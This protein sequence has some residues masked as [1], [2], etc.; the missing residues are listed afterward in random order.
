MEATSLTKEPDDVLEQERTPHLSYSRINRYLTCPEQYRLYYVENLRPKIE[1]ASLVFGGLIHVALADFFR[2]G[3]IP[4]DTFL[5]EWD[6]L[7]L[8]PLLHMII[9]LSRQTK[10]RCFNGLI[11]AVLAIGGIISVPTC[12]HPSAVIMVPDRSE[13]ETGL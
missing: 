8:T 5:R 11:R 9:Q 10:C 12:W 3:V 7:S 1:S 4:V 2:E 6:N 13:R